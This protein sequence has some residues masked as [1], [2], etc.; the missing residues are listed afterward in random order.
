[1]LSDYHLFTC[2]K[3]WVGSQRFSNNEE[4]IESIKTWLNEQ[5]A[6][7]SDTGIEKLIP[8]C[9]KCLSS[10]GDYVEKQLKYV[11]IFCIKQIFLLTAC[12]VNSSLE[13]TF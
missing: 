9:N 5:L 8:Q 4:L 1:M 7:F 10:S 3:N 13:V 2:L 12:F 11:C 6:D